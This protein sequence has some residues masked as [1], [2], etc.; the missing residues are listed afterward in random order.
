[1]KRRLKPTLSRPV[2]F[3]AFWLRTKDELSRVESVIRRE[4]LPQTEDPRLTHERIAFRSLGNAPI[5]GY[6]IRWP[7]DEKRPYVVHGHGYGSECDVQWGWAR[8]GL[9]VVGVNVRGYGGSTEALKNPSRWGKILTGIETPETSFLRGAVC[10]CMRA[11]Q[12]AERILGPCATRAVMHG[13]SFGGALALIAEACLQVAALLVIGVPTLGWAE[14]RNFLVRSGSGA[15]VIRYLE[16]R[17]ES[18]EDVMLVLR[19]FDPVNFAPLVKCPAL[20]GV[21]LADDVVPADTVY[22]VA[23]HLGGPHEIMEFPYSH[24]E[25]PQEVLWEK[26]EARWLELALR[27]DREISSSA[28]T[29]DGAAP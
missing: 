10:D 25:H 2:D 19:Y 23:N 28:G 4:P 16:D 12:V 18:S 9:N 20:V 24:S 14:G 26:F 13:A 1:M 11:A 29:P 17:P 7:G 22:A 5:E 15:E 3:E 21:G 27:G 8:A 6:L